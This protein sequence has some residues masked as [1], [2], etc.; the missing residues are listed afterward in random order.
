MV[1][2]F[3]CIAVPIASYFTYNKFIEKVF[4]VNPERATPAYTMTDGMD[5][6]PMSKK[7]LWLILF[8]Y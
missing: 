3:F 5:Y 4:V 2:F 1:W 8:S 6:L 7:K